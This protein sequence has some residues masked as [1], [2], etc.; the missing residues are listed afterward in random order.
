[1]AKSAGITP[2]VQ[3]QSA[4][5]LHLPKSTSKELS[6][7][8]RGS[9]EDQVFTNSSKDS[10]IK[11]PIQTL[12]IQKLLDEHGNLL[13]APA[14]VSH[15]ELKIQ[16]IKPYQAGDTSCTNQTEDNYVKSTESSEETADVLT[17]LPKKKQQSV[18]DENLKTDL[19][20]TEDFWQNIVCYICNCKSKY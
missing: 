13:K 9:N 17:P 3:V 20:L 2:I 18:L 10:L 4:R 15:E 16:E 8:S 14:V 6:L 5:K 19:N 7:A 12:S 11:I 1:M